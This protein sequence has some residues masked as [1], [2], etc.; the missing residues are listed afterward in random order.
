MA[1]NR[2]R[3][4]IGMTI[5]YVVASKACCRLITM[6][7]AATPRF[8]VPMGGPATSLKSAP[9]KGFVTAMSVCGHH[10]FD[11]ERLPRVTEQ[12]AIGQFRSELLLLR[13]LPGVSI[14]SQRKDFGSGV[15]RL[16]GLCFDRLW[17]G[18]HGSI[19]WGE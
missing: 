10:P 13:A 18:A 15:E 19:S 14:T 12:T 5:G 6:R 3:T 2:A 11:N 1:I 8:R 9:P 16:A 4:G 17:H 7:S